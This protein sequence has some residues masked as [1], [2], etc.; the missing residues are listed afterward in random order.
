MFGAAGHV[1]D[2]VEQIHSGLR[3]LEPP[4]LYRNLEGRFQKSDLGALPAIAGR[5][6]AFGDLNNDGG[7][8]R[9]R[10]RTRWESHCHDGKSERK[11]LADAEADGHA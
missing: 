3:Y 6:A 2:N 5:G 8:G 4:V 7:G 1:L 11:S 9:Y 10:L